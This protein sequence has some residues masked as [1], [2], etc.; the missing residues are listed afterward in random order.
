M[1]KQT[2]NFIKI[3]VGSFNPDTRILRNPK[4]YS[5]GLGKRRSKIEGSVCSGRSV[6]Y[7]NAIH[8]MQTIKWLEFSNYSRSYFA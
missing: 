1:K 7:P 2:I 3:R 8:S 4:F 6:F 5:L